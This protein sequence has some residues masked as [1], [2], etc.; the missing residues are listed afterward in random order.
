M[1]LLL[2]PLFLLILYD[3]VKVLAV[4][5]K[6][7]SEGEIRFHTLFLTLILVAGGLL[8]LVIEGTNNSR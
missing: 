2:S 5:W 8:V 1:Y 7:H 4:A 3:R 6:N